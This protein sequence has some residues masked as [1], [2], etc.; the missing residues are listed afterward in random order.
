MTTETRYP[1]RYSKTRKAVLA[2]ITEGL[3]DREIAA[4]LGTMGISI[5]FQAV[6]QW[7]LKN[8]DQIQA[9]VQH[10][11]RDIEAYAV[12]H[13][14]NRIATL[15][16]LATRLES[17]LDAEDVTYHEETRHGSKI[18]AHPAVSELRQTL[19]QAALE[20]DQLPR[21]GITVNNQNVVIVKQVRL[22]GEGNPEL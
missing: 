17:K 13:K 9:V 3:T 15:D 12:G 20:R 1:F 10:I 7:R 4:R 19:A 22:E 2:G 11:E 8:T 21:A 18:H 5:S 6:S 14:V 16:K